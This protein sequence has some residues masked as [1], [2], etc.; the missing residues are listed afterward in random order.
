MLKSSSAILEAIFHCGT[1]TL[2]IRIIGQVW[3]N[4]DHRQDWQSVLAKYRLYNKKVTI[5]IQS[6]QAKAGAVRIAY[7]TK[8]KR[9]VIWRKR[10][11]WNI[12]PGSNREINTEKIHWVLFIVGAL[13]INY[14]PKKTLFTI[15]SAE[16]V[17]STTSACPAKSPTN[18]WRS[19]PLVKLGWS[20]RSS[21]LKFT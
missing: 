16:E 7:S 9:K 8:I 2:V 4:S 20:H 6:K 3:S 19:S 11:W 10:Q 21:C 1:L 17:F 14:G 15:P 18:S 12:H 5:L 13:N